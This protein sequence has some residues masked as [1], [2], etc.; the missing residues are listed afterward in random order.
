MIDWNKP[1]ETI[2]GEPVRV[3]ATDLEDDTYPIAVAYKNSHSEKVVR[4]VTHDGR[5]LTGRPI[6]FRNKKKRVWINLYKPLRYAIDKTPLKEGELIQAYIHFDS[7][8]AVI[9]TKNCIGVT[10][11]TFIAT[12]EVEI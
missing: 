7:E 11:E 6:K 5:I 1:V 2:D 8:R 9:D 4:S 12:V 10:P 3:L